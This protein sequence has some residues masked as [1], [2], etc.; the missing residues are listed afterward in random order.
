MRLNNIYFGNKLNFGLKLLLENAS[1]Q[2]FAAFLNI[3]EEKVVFF[4]YKMQV[5][6]ESV[7]ARRRAAKIAKSSKS[8]SRSVQKREISSEERFRR[9]RELISKGLSTNQISKVLKV[10]ERSVTRFKR[11]MREEKKRLKAEGK[12]AI[13]PN[14][15]DDDNN[16]KHLPTEQK[17]QVAKE[18]FRKRLKIQEIS[19][20]LKISE[21]SVRRWKDRLANETRSDNNEHN[22]EDSVTEGRAKRAPKRAI[23]FDQSSQ[24]EDEEIYYEEAPPEHTPLPKKRKLFV[25]REKV[26]YARELIENK[27]SNKEMSKLLEL[28]IACVRKLKL[29]ILNGTVEELID[30]SEEHYTNIGKTATDGNIETKA[31]VA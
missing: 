1:D 17:M 22:Y 15:P 30:D 13:D 6:E 18:M 19:E 24:Q 11:R 3:P 10:S 28:T 21:R 12:I 29:K 4:K 25:D 26:E 2:E 9:A 5:F 20:I 8:A 31:F 23:E 27:M 14:D 16:F 7:R